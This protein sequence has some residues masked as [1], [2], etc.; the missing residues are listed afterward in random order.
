M[1]FLIILAVPASAHAYRF[2]RWLML[3][4]N[5]RGGLVVYLIALLCL[6][7]PLYRYV[8]AV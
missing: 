7:L 6:A 2:G 8:S 5:R 4:G 3:N 1:T